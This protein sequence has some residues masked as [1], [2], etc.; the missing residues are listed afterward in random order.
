MDQLFYLPGMKASIFL[1]TK[2]TD[3]YRV[4]S[5]SMPFI[6]QVLAFGSADGYTAYDG[7][8]GVTGYLG[9]DGYTRDLTQIAV[10][11]Y[12][13]QIIL[14]KTASAVGS[15]FVDV[16]YTNPANNNLNTQSYQIVVSAP[17]GMYSTTI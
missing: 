3:G 15:Y 6:S 13:A 1:E 4:D 8:F 7:Y 16:H 11:S 12:F 2:D 10:G 17:F 5:S 9:T 14:P